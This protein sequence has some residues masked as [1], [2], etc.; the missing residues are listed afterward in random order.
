MT[1]CTTCSANW[2]ADQRRVG[3]IHSAV[4]IFPHELANSRCVSQP[5][6]EQLDRPSRDH[7]PN[8]FLP[9]RNAGKQVHPFRQPGQTVAIG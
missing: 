3:K 8:G 4:S 5:R 6:I 2:R 9:L 7:L 1:I